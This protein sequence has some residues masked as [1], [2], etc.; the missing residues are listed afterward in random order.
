MPCTGA[1]STNSAWTLPR[2][3]RPRQVT[4]RIELRTG[5]G[6]WTLVQRGNT[7]SRTPAPNRRP[8]GTVL[9]KGRQESPCEHS[10]DDRGGGR[11]QELTMRASSILLITGTVLSGLTMPLVAAP[12]PEPVW[13]AGVSQICRAGRRSA[14]EAAHAAHPAGSLAG[15][16]EFSF[17]QSG[18]QAGL[19]I[20]SR[21]PLC[22]LRRRDQPDAI[23]P[24]GRPGIGRR[25][26]DAT[27]CLRPL[28]D[29][30]H[31]HDVA[32]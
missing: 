18:R 9:S 1:A 25:Q 32:R 26:G 16:P 6:N 31:E 2:G 13:Q 10:S 28:R 21:D 29:E 27:P 14:L 11:P 17:P 23:R 30:A 7:K 4:E 20:R 8:R 22:L 24:G 15:F 5:A 12:G 19:Q 3:L